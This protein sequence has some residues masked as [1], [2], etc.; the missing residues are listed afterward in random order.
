[1][2]EITFHGACH[3]GKVVF[4]T[5]GLPAAS[6]ACHCSLCRR[7][8]SAPYAEMVLY[9]PECMAIK[10]APAPPAHTAHLHAPVHTCTHLHTP[11]H[12]CIP[13]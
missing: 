2:A 6:V 3:C 13:D 1:M 9:T 8:H 12:T 11:A 7:C 4:E 5:T 10:Q